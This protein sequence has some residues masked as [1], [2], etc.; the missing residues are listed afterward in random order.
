MPRQP[1]DAHVVAEVLAAELR[2]DPER[3]GELED[4]LLQLEVPEPV[5]GHGA[6]G[7][8][9]VEVVRRGVLGGLQSELRGGAADHDRQVVRRAG[10]PP[11]EGADLLLEEAQEPLRVQDRLRLLEEEGLVGRAAALGHE[12]EL[13]LRPPRRLRRG[14]D[15]DLGGQVG[16]GVL[17]V[18]RRERRQLAVAQVQP[19]V[20]LVD[21]AGDRLGVVGTGQHALGLLAH[22]DR[23]AR[24]LAHR[25]HP[26]RRDRGVLEQVE[27][28]E[29]VVGR[30]LGVVV[31]APELGK[32]GRPQVVGDV[33]HRLGAQPTDRVGVHLEEGA[34]VHLERGDAIGG[35]EPVRRPVGPGRQEVGVAEVGFAGHERAG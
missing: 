17:L 13:V 12:E 22:H 4:L 15:L 28:D 29:P 30:R 27:G 24:V 26:A 18:V 31:D 10:R 35:Q 33:A 21:T 32:V 16:A 25:Q 6:R 34:A 20:G 11:C 7:R 8:Q 3:P 2:P 23:G 5:G 1:H 9:L 14:V 19:R